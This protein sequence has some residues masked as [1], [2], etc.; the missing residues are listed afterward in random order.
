[1]SSLLPQT[2][3]SVCSVSKHANNEVRPTLG[4]AHAHILK[5]DTSLR[6]AEQTAAGGAAETCLFAC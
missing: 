5:S 3:M 6:S 2:E 1:M 4:S